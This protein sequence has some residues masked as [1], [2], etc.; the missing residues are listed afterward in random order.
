MAWTGPYPTWVVG[1]VSLASD[2]N[3]Y[4]AGNGSWL[5]VRPAGRLYAATQTACANGSLTQI[6][7]GTTDYLQ[8]GMTTSTNTLIIPVAGIYFCT[9]SVTWGIVAAGGT[10]WTAELFKN[11]SAVRST[12][13]NIY[14][15]SAS[16]VLTSGDS[17][18][19]AAGDTLT[20]YGEQ[21]SGQS[22]NTTASSLYTYLSATLV[23]GTTTT[24]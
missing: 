18:S 13:T 8:G 11:G 23:S 5:A 12:I 17:V 10:N 24:G 20:L 16:L 15:G 14:T 22:E 9:W 6:T 19:C 2:W 3:T 7:L 1:Q 4:V 21:S